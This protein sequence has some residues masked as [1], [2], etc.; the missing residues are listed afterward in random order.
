MSSLDTLDKIK[1]SIERHFKVDLNSK[2]R[3]RD[4][5]DARTMYCYIAK[6]LTDASTTSIG[7]VIN[8]DHAT[9][10]HHNKKFNALYSTDK[11]FKR[12]YK[13]FISEHEDRIK[14]D[15]IDKEIEWHS[16]KLASLQLRKE[17]LLAHG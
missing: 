17:K 8:R 16:G 5:V 7:K 13:D 11:S 6:Q 15:D 2:K 1:E 9:V 3:S 12:S 4:I 14:L 10:L